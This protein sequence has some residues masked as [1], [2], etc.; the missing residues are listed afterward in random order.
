M[1]YAGLLTLFLFLCIDTLTATPQVSSVQ[2]HFFSEE[3]SIQY[4]RNILVELA[5]PTQENDM[6]K[7]YKTLEQRNYKPLLDDLL[8]KKRQLELNDWLFYELMKRAVNNI[9]GKGSSARVELTCWFLLSKAGFDTRL[10][11]LKEQQFVYVYT[12]D[13]VFEVPMIREQGRDYANLT[14][15]RSKGKSNEALYMVNFAPNPNGK[16]FG[17]YL[18]YLPLLKTEPEKK[19]FTFPY[20]DK[21]Y[22]LDVE[23]DKTSA[24]IMEYYP[25]IEE[26]Q[27]LQVPLSRTLAKSLLPQLQNWVTGLTKIQALELLASFTRSSFKYKEDKEY[28]GRSKPMIADE[29]FLYPYSDCEDRSALFFCLVKELV[30]LPM[31]IVAF[32]DHL[33]IGVALEEEIGDAIRYEGK[34]YY[35]CDPTGPVNSADIGAFPSGYQHTKF[36]IIG[37][38][39]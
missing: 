5:R 3:L 14:S 28:F 23:V 20:R 37:K 10:T 13:E 19:H 21:V 27:Y 25:F 24:E 30:D 32:P 29:V 35:I 18:P 9:V 26:Q 1:K 15:I 12:T 6:V 17:F 16:A 34:N 33:T 2:V 22:E 31:I 38:Y 7:F 11:Y 8:E 36:K 39:K 4:D